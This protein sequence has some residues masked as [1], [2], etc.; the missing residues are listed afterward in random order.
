LREDFA[1]IREEPNL[2]VAFSGDPEE[3]YEVERVDADGSATVV[4]ASSSP[5]ILV[6]SKAQEHRVVAKN[7]ELGIRSTPSVP[8]RE[9]KPDHRWQ[10]PLPRNLLSDPES[11]DPA[12][13]TWEAQNSVT[14]DGRVDNVGPNGGSAAQFTFPGSGDGSDGIYQKSV[15]IP[16]NFQRSSG[17]FVRAKSG[18]INL[19]YVQFGGSSNLFPTLN[20][21]WV[22]VK[23]EGGG[24]QVARDFALVDDGDA[25]S[26]YV[27]RA[28][29]NIGSSLEYSTRSEVPQEIP[30]VVQGADLSNGST[31]SADTNDLDFGVDSQG[32][33]YAVSGGDDRTE[34]I[35]SSAL[36]GTWAAR[37]Y[38]ALGS[39]VNI[40][41]GDRNSGR[42]DIVHVPGQS[43]LLV[44]LNDV[45]GNSYF[46]VIDTGLNEPGWNTVV[47]TLD[48]STNTIRFNVNGNT[49][50]VTTTADFKDQTFPLLNVG[51]TSGRVQHV[52]KHPVLTPA[53]AEAVRQRLA[54][55]PSDPVPPTEAWDS[56]VGS[57]S[58]LPALR[59]SS[60]DISVGASVSWVG[61]IGLSDDGGGSLLT[62]TKRPTVTWVERVNYTATRAFGRSA[63]GWKVTAT[64]LVVEDTNSNTASAAHGKTID[65]G[66]YHTLAVT[67]DEVAGVAEVYIDGATSPDATV[68]LS[69]VGTLKSSDVELLAEGGTIKQPAYYTRALSGEEIAYLHERLV[70]NPQSPHPEYTTP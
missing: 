32:V 63:N 15:A 64:D 5:D 9:L 62:P 53:E 36:G 52:E 47:A 19:K 22:W 66:A 6:P 30:D 37:I 24:G 57:G 17:L 23:I 55:N 58:T 13:T 14:Y 11:F 69:T 42:W 20:T 48:E 31:D 43:R 41:L 49:T 45:D 28:A 26:I 51:V 46:A 56:T 59:Q 68:D 1:V 44:R 70:D 33:P 50:S 65:D 27:L 12:T 21:D 54:Q 2:R 35:P 16:A 25:G 3:E 10:M 40:Y 34:E 67:I 38:L 39:R 8:K 18:T 4:G 61:P 7:K 60:N 29:C